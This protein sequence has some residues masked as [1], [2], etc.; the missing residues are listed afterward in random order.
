MTRRPKIGLLMAALL[1][2][3][4]AQVPPNT[5]GAGV[6]KSYTPVIDLQGVDGT[7]Y[8]NDLT[9]CRDYSTSIDANKEA[10]G[11][12]IAGIILG[13]ALGASVGGGDARLM[14]SGASSGA[15]IGSTSQ[16]NRAVGR[17]E[18]IIANCMAGRG[19]KVVDGSAT[20]A[21]GQPATPLSAPPSQALMPAPQAQNTV[22]QGVSVSKPAPPSGEDAFVAGKFGRDA[23]CGALDTPAVLAAKGPGYETYSMA[24]TNGDTLMMR[25]EL[26]NCRALR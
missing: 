3:G 8:M 14:E 19:Y 25:C 7:R 24:C 18:R 23:K 15:I 1:L 5:P 11:G 22:I 6:G 13:A 16:G 10:L 17:Q 4:C 2:A 12:M 9:A 21:I 20:V 26:G